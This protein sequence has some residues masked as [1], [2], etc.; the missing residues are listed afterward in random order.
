METEK[1]RKHLKQKRSLSFVNHQNNR[2]LKNF[3]L[4]IIEIEGAF[5]ISGLF[6]RWTIIWIQMT[7]MDTLDSTELFYEPELSGTYY[8]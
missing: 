4:N 3:P 8:R 2:L 1:S 5:S 7:Q 6:R